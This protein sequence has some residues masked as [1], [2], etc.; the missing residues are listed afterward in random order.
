MENSLKTTLGTSVCY[1]LAITTTPETIFL[2]RQ[3]KYA[4]G[5]ATLAECTTHLS[6]VACGQWR[7]LRILV[8]LIDG[9]TRSFARTR[10]S[11]SY[12][13]KPRRRRGGLSRASGA[14]DGASASLLPA[15]LCIDWAW[16]CRSGGPCARGVDFDPYPSAYIRPVAT[17]HALDLCNRALQIS[18]LSPADQIV[19]QGRADGD[20]RTAYGQQRPGC[21]RERIGF[22]APDVEDFGQGET[23]DSVREAGRTEH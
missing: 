12:D 2:H 22:A 8:Q 11:S 6:L 14:F 3:V 13:V 7:N 4:P 23:G 18:G 15:P 9:R 5:K 1:P 21:Y 17:F 19:V 20:R 16:S 10:A